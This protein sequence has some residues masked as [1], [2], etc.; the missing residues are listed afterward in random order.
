MDSG[1]HSNSD[2]NVDSDVDSD[3][4][5]VHWG[6]TAQRNM[7][8]DVPAVSLDFDLETGRNVDWTAELG[9]QTYGTPVV[10][11]N[12]VFVGTNNAKGRR[13][14]H[15]A[16]A[17]RGV[18]QCF[19]ATT[20]EFLWQLTREKLES[21]EA[22]DWPL[23]G[24]CSNPVVEG[25]RLWVVTNRAELM[26][27][28]VNGFR[29]GKNDGPF[30]D[31]VDTELEDADIIWSLDMIE[32]LGVYPHHLAT[33]SPVIY[34]DS[35]FV[36]T[37]NGVDES[38][39]EVP[40]PDSPSFLAVNKNTGQV[41]WSSNLP[42]KGILDGQWAS[43]AVGVVEGKAQVYF[44][45]GDGWLYALDAETGAEIWR[46]D[47][48]PKEALWQGSGRGDRNYM[49]ASP[50]FIENSVL[51]AAG[52]EPEHGD[53]VSYLYR[54]DATQK[55]DISAELGPIGQPGQPNPNSGL[56]WKYGGR[57]EADEFIFRRSISTV[58]VADNLVFVPDFTGFVHCVDFHSGQR[59]WE[60][61]M[62]ANVWGSTMVADGKVFV[63]NEDGSLVV[64][65]AQKESAEVLA[66]ISTVNFASIYGA[67]TFVGN[68][69]YLTDRTTLY[70][71]KIA[72]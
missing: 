40:A 35:V 14:Q 33:C 30:V 15:P 50:V 42:G 29:D 70:C 7:V 65:K 32:Q 38:G 22:N 18:L 2:S 72:E 45:G 28:D 36:L 19:D 48:N 47:L 39:T 8:S 71:V 27:L 63:G 64:F 17:D 34:G 67:P 55:G 3:V 6:G 59:H 21:G 53:G 46:F 57:D 4:D 41:L 12:R 24:I 52:Q 54:I 20:G 51:L 69:M 23:Q 31:E 16:D 56:I 68:K 1:S 49:I 43:P 60:H 11:G 25:D 13:P 44:P 66:E 37:S 9:S 58:S 10:V 61:D 5:L 26:C 62:L